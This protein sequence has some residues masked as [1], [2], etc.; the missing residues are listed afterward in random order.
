MAY[1]SAMYNASNVTMGSVNKK[2]EGKCQQR[3][4]R[5]QQH[6]K[7]G[8]P[9]GRCIF[10]LSVVSKLRERVRSYFDIYT[11]FPSDC[12]RNRRARLRSKTGAY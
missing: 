8:V 3:L 1:A 10:A 9:N 4:V 7:V 2:T 5:Q 12:F 11:V 6:I